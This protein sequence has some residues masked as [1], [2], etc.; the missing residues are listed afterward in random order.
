MGTTAPGYAS[1]ASTGLT[2]GTTYGFR[3]RAANSTGFSSYS[4]VATVTTPTDK[5]LV[6]VVDRA[7]GKCLDVLGGGVQPNGQDVWLWTCYG[8]PPV[9][10][11]WLVPATGTSGPVRVYDTKCLDAWTAQGNAGDPIKIYDCIAGAANQQWTHT[12]LGELKGI[13]GLCVNLKAGGAASD[14]S[15]YLALGACADAGSRRWNIQASAPPTDQ[16]PVA[17]FTAGCTNLSCTFD[18]GASSDDKGIASRSWTFGDGT[19][20]DNGSVSGT[21]VAPTKT[22]AAAG[23]Y[24]VTL[25]VTD[26]AGQTSSQAKGVSVTA[27]PVPAPVAPS[28][29]TAALPTNS[30]IDL[31][32]TDNSTTETAFHVERC[33]GVGCTNFVEYAAVAANATSYQ[34]P[35]L[36]AGTS[37]SYRVHAVNGSAESANSNVATAATP[38]AAN[39]APAAAFTHACTNLSCT[40]TDASTDADG[41]VAG[42]SWNFGDNTGSTLKGPTKSYAA[43]GTYTVTLTV[44]DDKGA[45][46]TTS[47]DVTVTAPAPAPAPVDLRASGYK[48]KGFQYV[49]LTWS[50]ATGANVDV[51][52]NEMKV[53]TTP[54]DGSHVDNLQQKGGA[55]YVYKVCEAGTTVCSAGVTVVF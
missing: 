31:A 30:R 12:S 34:N 41:T 47:K 24:T 45:S 17:S 10:Q 19:T 42:W 55:T 32:W 48:S 14:G 40:F 9:N 38:A 3:V 50:R 23:S 2:A 13:N 29:L 15:G 22:Y 4:N 43:A 53:T 6:P 36:A 16:P 37:F 49:T 25:T 21:V 46:G 26:A 20:Q 39:Q 44:T 18:S 54:N 51:L 35:G 8:G 7:S 11:A 33:V 1:F 5:G 28:A 27:P 52:R